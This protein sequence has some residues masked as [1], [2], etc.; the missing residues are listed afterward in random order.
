MPDDSEFRTYE[1]I[2]QM[3]S[4]HGWNTKNPARNAGGMVYTQGEFYNHDDLLTA[5]LGRETPEN[6]IIIPWENGVRYWFVEAKRAHSDHG[7]ALEEAQGYADKVNASLAGSARFATGIAGTPDESFYVTTT[8][9]NGSEWQQVV[10]NNYETTGFLTLSQCLG[11]LDRNDPRILHYDVDLDNFLIKANDIN[12]SLHSN[13]VA[14]K[15]R[16][17]VVAGLLL[18]LVQ[19]SSL[20]IT[21][22]PRTLISDINTRIGAL[23]RQHGKEDFLPE[24]S[25]RLPNTPE[26]HR[27]YWNAIVRTMQHLREMNIRSA[28][29]SGTDA[30]GQFYETF[31]K[32]ANDASEMGIVLTPRHITKFAVDVL[33]IRHNDIIFDPACGTGG[34][35]VAALDS[36]RERHHT[37]HPDVYDTFR[38][39][40]LFGIEDSDDV[41]GLAL[42]NMIFRGDGKSRI[43]S[44]NCFDYDFYDQ[45]GEVTRLRSDETPAGPHGRPFSRV[46]MN[47]PF[48]IEEKERTFV[49]YALRQMRPGGLLFAILPNG[50]ITGLQHD[51][52]WRRELVQRHTVRAVVRMQ[53]KLFSPNVNKGTYGIVLE[54][55]RPHET[56]DPVYFAVLYDDKHASYKSKTLSES[57]AQD[58]VDRITR[59]LARFLKDNRAVVEKVDR[60]ST[61]ATLDTGSLCDFASEAYL[62][63]GPPKA[64]V[65]KPLKQLFLV[66]ARNVV[67]EQSGPPEEPP[68]TRQ[69]DLL[70]LFTISRGGGAFHDIP[71]RRP[72]SRNH[73]QHA[74]ERY[75]WVL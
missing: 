48:A 39:D 45:S 22:S 17:R 28:I 43:H 59:D 15:D 75:R 20:R 46:L 64:G 21:E 14:A 38:N 24:V 57:K 49:D 33:N 29:N 1:Y 34:F 13:G 4:K 61:V 56:D 37:V 53:N 60:E 30:L 5:A 42:V 52:K 3:L 54:A 65:S 2:R 11:V 18:A 72:Y 7:L 10:I 6:T 12:N 8:H 26:N 63:S 62:D 47:P 35:L 9:W 19:D 74:M 31:L 55:W 44:G 66:M 23:L 36:V 27:K 71:G 67:R 41:F 58:N 73:M 68:V 25:L 50:P 70:D 51:M 69:F 16:A 40:C 32:Y